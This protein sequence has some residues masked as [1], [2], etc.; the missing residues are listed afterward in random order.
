MTVQHIRVV[1]IVNS[2]DDTS[3]IV[4]ELQ[5]GGY[6]VIHEQVDNAADLDKAL[7]I[8]DWDIVLSDFTLPSFDAIEAL[9]IVRAYDQDMPFIVITDTI[10][11][12]VAV[13]VMKA[14]ASDL[15][16]TRKL[17]LLVPAV[18]RE[19]RDAQHR[20]QR[21][22]AEM[23]LRLAEERFAAT[24]HASP[25]GIVIT[26]MSDGR[27]IDANDEF[28]RLSGYSREQ[29][30][31]K[32][33]DEVKL[34]VND[35]QR[36][37]IAD[38]LQNH[39]AVRSVEVD[40]RRGSGETGVALLSTA[41]IE[42]DGHTCV[43]SMVYD[44]TERK[45]AQQEV[46]FQAELL[47]RVGQAVVATDLQG[48]IIYWN[49]AAEQL[50]GWTF[51][52]V[53][54][55]DITEIVGSEA[56]M[57][58]TEA[59]MKQIETGDVWRGELLVRRKDGSAVP[60]LV[61]SAPVYDRAGRPSGFVG[62]STDISQLKSIESA[63]TES[64]RFARATVDAL[65]ANIAILDETGRIVAVNQPW[66][67]FAINNGSRDENAY[68]GANYLDVCERPT[69]RGSESVGKAAADGIRAVIAGEREVFTLEYDCHSPI[70]RRWFSVH[71]TRFRGEGPVRVVVAHEDITQSRES[72][73]R[74]RL[75]HEIGTSL[76]TVGV[77]DPQLLYTILYEQVARR[78]FDAPHFVIAQYN[79][80]TETIICEFAIVDNEVTDPTLFPPRKMGT[81]P[82]AESIR[83]RRTVIDNPAEA[84]IAAHN[85]PS[86]LIG[87]ER[88]P[89]SGIYIPLIT[90]DR[91]YGVMTMQHY[92]ANVFGEED[93]SLIATIA[94]QAATALENAYLYR[95]VQSYAGTLEQRVR[96]RTAELERAKNWVESILSS[97]SDVIVLADR[98]GVL[99][100][101]NSAFE[102]QFQYESDELINRSLENIMARSSGPALIDAIKTAI[103]TGQ[104]VDLDSI[105]VR[106][107]G[108]LFEAELSITSLTSDSGDE[109]NVVCV[110]HDVTR[111]KQIEMSLRA[112]LE[113]EKELNELKT[114]FSSMVSHEFRT[115]LS[116]ILSSAGLLRLY[117]ERLSEERRLAKLI[118]IEYQVHRMVNML[119]NILSL[120]RAES[121]ELDV[122][123]EKVELDDL[124]REITR[125]IQQT[126]AAH[127]ISLVLTGQPYPVELDPDLI[128]DV[129]RN[130]LSNAVKYTPNGGV[131]HV[132]CDF[133]DGSVLLKV[134][135]RGMGIPEED[136]R[137]V[138]DAFHRAKNVRDVSGTGLGLAIV[139]NA[140]EAHG[141][142]VHLESKIGVGTTFT[143]TL[144]A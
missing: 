77:N 51:D 128:G 10:E 108:S 66:I 118:G 49:R 90:G 39:E 60:T 80:E 86:A 119:D 71:V 53:R 25:I 30:I 55:H 85:D 121:I 42:L 44:I 40:F 18:E 83:Q 127:D 112:S 32:N 74:L 82:I 111:H 137:H 8:S 135:D 124:C 67:D 1:V 140:V 58:A 143:V 95:T 3:V 61:T 101:A 104:T 93:V 46:S 103:E 35:A 52:E 98:Q 34:W 24:F 27:V 12:E 41:Q 129:I 76:T 92:D 131:I 5:R 70:K 9:G 11:D 81:G 7:R 138:F 113:K 97:T 23:E 22:L 2:E 87:D 100:Q 125:E 114:R 123:R 133:A 89:Q 73:E 63:L 134:T 29:L 126:T 136:Q 17:A 72:A 4:S 62:V 88:I 99:I 26:R 31:G 16:A 102:Q 109:P 105:C 122:T 50:Y 110:I 116:V 37:E 36:Q 33:G 20:R 59:I 45:R 54:S 139:K 84:H 57:M 106:Q 115:P 43:L 21:R 79:T 14:G 19:I 142:T 96:D 69:R 144:P 141:G 78:M 68:L 13:S 117:A 94:G 38:R 107:D 75:L 6:E 47:N 28:L 120:S 91:I 132:Q 56:P 48:G 130:L 65:T 15:F 64:E